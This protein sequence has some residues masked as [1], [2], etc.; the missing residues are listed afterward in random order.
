[1]VIEQEEMMESWAKMLGS[2]MAHN[3]L[4]PEDGLIQWLHWLLVVNS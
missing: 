3:K 2:F 4:D 1:V